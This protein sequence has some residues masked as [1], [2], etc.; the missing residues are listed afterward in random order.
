MTSIAESLREEGRQ[1][2]REQLKRDYL[3]RVAKRLLDMSWSPEEI[4]EITELSTDEIKTLQ[5][6]NQA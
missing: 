4:A 3:K 2:A 5:V 1:Q 6:A